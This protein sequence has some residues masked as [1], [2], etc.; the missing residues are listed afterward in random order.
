MANNVKVMDSIKNFLLKMKALDEQLPEELAQ[1]AL[2]M[3]EEVKD[4]LAEDKPEE[5]KDESLEEAAT[6]E[7][8]KGEPVEDAC[9]EGEIEKK[10]E[11]AMVKVLRKYGLVQ[12]S[13]MKA[14]DELEKEIVETKETSDV[15]GEEAVTVDPET[16]NDTAALLRKVKPVIAGVKDS[17]QRKILSDSF[18]QAIKMN[19][20]T[21]DYSGVAK[22][23]KANAADSMANV[24]KASDAD[25]DLGM[26][27]AKKFNPHY[28]K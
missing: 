2:E 18:A 3:T 4:A 10:V 7:P 27:I 25:Y 15:D 20:K 16:M 23:A 13:A 19:T 11:D 14:L 28:T 9:V 8:K 21:A 22:L 1:D 24:K 17:K 6:G 26:E 12:D 5:A